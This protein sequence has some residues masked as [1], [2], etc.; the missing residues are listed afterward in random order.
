MLNWLTYKVLAYIAASLGVVIIGLSVALWAQGVRV[1]K[2]QNERDA[3]VNRVTQALQTID[4]QKKVLQECSDRTQALKVE[5]DKKVAAADQAVLQARK[6][7]AKYQQANQKRSAALLA[8]TPQGAG[9]A[10]AIAE[11]RRDLRP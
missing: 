2:A 10:Q 9:C 8:P 6:D 7:A 1:G 11:A 4:G 3:A 5:S